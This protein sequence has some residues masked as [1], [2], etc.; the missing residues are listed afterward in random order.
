MKRKSVL[1]IGKHRY[2]NHFKALNNSHNLKQQKAEIILFMY[3]KISTH[4]HHYHKK[5]AYLKEKSNFV[6]EK[7]TREAWRTSLH[8][9]QEGGLGLGGRVSLELLLSLLLQQLTPS[10]SSMVLHHKIPVTTNGNGFSPDCK[11]L[12]SSYNECKNQVF[13]ELGFVGRSS[14][15]KGNIKQHVANAGIGEKGFTHK[16]CKERERETH[17]RI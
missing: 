17:R 4:Q 2:Q 8:W 7:L 10:I 12:L 9:R 16:C 14:R 3:R 6:K 1:K 15:F 13:Q 11:N 5:N